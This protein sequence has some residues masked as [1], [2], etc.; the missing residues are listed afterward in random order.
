MQRAKYVG[1]AAGITLEG[2]ASSNRP[3]DT[4]S[5]PPDAGPWACVASLCPRQP[6]ARSTERAGPTDETTGHAHKAGGT[7]AQGVKYPHPV[8]SDA[9]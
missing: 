9:R 7:P 1:G 4:Y 3:F 5:N 8:Y 6:L 2:Q